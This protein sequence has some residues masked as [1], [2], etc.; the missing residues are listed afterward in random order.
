M[1][2]TKYYCKCFFSICVVFFSVS[3]R[4]REAYAIVLYLTILPCDNILPIANSE[5]SVVGTKD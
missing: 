4:L 1:S 3:L 5:A 2:K